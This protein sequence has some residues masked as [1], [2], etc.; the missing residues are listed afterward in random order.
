MS[1]RPSPL[2]A[3]AFGAL[4]GLAG[5]AL[6]T[7]YQELVGRLRGGGTEKQPRRWRDAPAP[8][9]IG[10]KVA[11][12]VDQKVTLADAPKLTN[13][14]HWAYGTSW[15]AAYGLG[16]GTFAS[17]PVSHGL[18]FGTFVWAFSYATLTPLGIYEPPWKYPPKEFAIDLSYH[19]LYG[20][21]VAGA[22]R[23]LERI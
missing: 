12:A 17:R 22:Y 13:A 18:G 7:G 14:V 16:E 6:M 20:L 5:T 15:G 2:E 21:G 9:Q 11:D 10:K 8:A 3:L 23:L 1:E 19:L 4:A